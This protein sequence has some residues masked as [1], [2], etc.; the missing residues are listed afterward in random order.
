MMLDTLRRHVELAFDP[1]ARLRQAKW[2]HALRVGIAVLASIGLTT[3]LS[4]P[5]GDWATITVLVV[6]GGFQHH[7]NIRTRGIERAKGTILGAFIGLLLVTQQHYLSAP[8]VTYLLLAVICG[9]C[10][11]HA[12]GSGGYVALL[13]GV[14]IV[15]AAGHG[16]NDVAEGIW[17]TINVLIGTLIALL[18]SM[19]F[20]SYAFHA[21]RSRLSHLLRQGGDLIVALED[22]DVA[23]PNP[24]GRI[25]KLNGWLM[26][27]RS[28]MASAAK[29]SAISIRAF[30]DVQH[31]VRMSV[32]LLEVIVALRRKR[33]GI[34]P[35]PMGLASS[36]CRVIR[37]QFEL[38]ADVLDGQ[39][40]SV[41]IES[42][43]AAIPDSDDA[44]T[45][46]FNQLAEELVVL[47]KRLHPILCQR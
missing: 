46:I 3:G 13:A 29:E 38:L 6:I 16:T 44:A 37:E 12:I 14:T 7:G 24:D 10:A 5:H 25:G 11:Y 22:F 23:A 35:D 34:C 28:L 21:W 18:L 47:R 8:V 39:R 40:P 31:C 26:Q 2:F 45:V 4:L 30:E 15:I 9:Y 42:I 27:L 41:I 36:A 32:C 20:P 43:P 19:A 17:R 1:F 33:A